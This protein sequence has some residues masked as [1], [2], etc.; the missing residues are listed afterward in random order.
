MTADQGQYEK[1][2]EPYTQEA[3]RNHPENDTISARFNV[4]GGR[5]NEGK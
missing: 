2:M 3:K 1:F 5:K 4:S